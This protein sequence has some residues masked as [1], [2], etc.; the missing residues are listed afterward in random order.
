MKQFQMVGN[1]FLLIEETNT[2]IIA[3]NYE[4]VLS[5][6]SDLKN[7]LIKE[8]IQGSIQLDMLLKTGTSKNRFA[9]IEFD[10]ERFIRSSSRILKFKEEIKEKTTMFFKTHTELFKNC[11]LTD[12]QISLAKGYR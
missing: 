4:S 3:A 12:D 8:G 6:D 1:F 2:Y 9:S 5:H 11:T 7:A 10:G